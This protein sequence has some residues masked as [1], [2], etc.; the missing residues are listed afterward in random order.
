MKSN[1]LG[2]AIVLGAGLA[3]AMAL[4]GGSAAAQSA[5]TPV[6]TWAWFN[7]GQVVLGFD[8]SAVGT[9]GEPGT[10]RADDVAARR[11]VIQWASGWVDTM[12][13]SPDGVML[14]GSN[15]G[16]GRVWGK[17]KDA[18]LGWQLAGVYEGTHGGWQDIVILMADGTLRRGQGDAGRWSF[19]GAT[20]DLAWANA[21]A[22]HLNLRRAGRFVRK[23]PRFV[24]VKRAE[25]SVAAY[26]AS[27]RQIQRPQV[28]VVETQP[29]PQV[30]PQPVVV[31]PPP[32]V[33]PAP[34][35]VVVEPPQ[36]APTQ[37]IVV[38]T[39]PPPPPTQVVVVDSPPV[40]VPRERI[41][42]RWDRVK[43]RGFEQYELFPSGRFICTT[44]TTKTTG[45]WSYAE[46]V[47]RIV[48]PTSG[49]RV[50]LE[51]RPSGNLRTRDRSL[52]LSKVDGEAIPPAT[53]TV[54]TTTVTTTEAKP[55]TTTEPNPE[56]R[57]RPRTRTKPETKPEVTQ[58]EPPKM[59]PHTAMPRY[60]VKRIEGQW[61][62]EVRRDGT[63]QGGTVVF[64]A[65][66]TYTDSRSAGG[67]W[68]FNGSNLVLTMP[69]G[70]TDTLRRIRSTYFRSPSTRRVLSR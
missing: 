19:D 24:L 5:P 12:T 3:V 52:V 36:P 7:N 11:Y 28:L 20:L 23:D 4:C 46:G 22:E 45:R 42:G 55:E 21:P 13:L 29:A 10:W 8:G 68:T 53:T 44:Q 63:R 32:V 40:I 57:R 16:G 56:P 35:P 43:A 25:P 38:E 14:E 62:T 2:G 59:R 31:A 30:Q 54:T 39:P 64:N 58:S 37:V 15:A 41:V 60:L 70:N 27:L 17:R 66:G 33:E 65:D 47:V 50:R 48:W 34:A 18:A 26:V 69:D 1:V 67:T 61:T 9:Q 6:G 51:L 49:R